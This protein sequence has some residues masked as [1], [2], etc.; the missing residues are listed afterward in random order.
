MPREDVLSNGPT[1]PIRAT[2]PVRP[3]S[4]CPGPQPN[5]HDE[6]LACGFGEGG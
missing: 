3:Q 2:L 1:L 4:D 5:A 6:P